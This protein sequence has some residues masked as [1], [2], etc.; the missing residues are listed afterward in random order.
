MCDYSAERIWSYLILC[1]CSWWG[2]IVY[3]WAWGGT[4]GIRTRLGMRRRRCEG[5]PR[6]ARALPTPDSLESARSSSRR[7][8]NATQPEKKYIKPPQADRPGNILLESSLPAPA[9]PWAILVRGHAVS[10]SLIASR[11]YMVKF[12]IFGTKIVTGIGGRPIRAKHH[13]HQFYKLIWGFCSCFI[14]YSTC[15]LVHVCLFVIVKLGLKVAL[16]NCN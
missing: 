14:L 13:L 2:G 5:V 8:M 10:H 16:P 11:L 7:F 4:P 3:L 9:Q 6:A 1:K 12:N 15:N